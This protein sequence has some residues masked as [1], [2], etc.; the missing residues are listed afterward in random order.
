MG[1]NNMKKALCKKGAFAVLGCLVLESSPLLAQSCPGDS[2]YTS[3]NGKIFNNAQP[4]STTLGIVHLQS[5]VFG[6]MKCGII[7]VPQPGSDNSLSEIKFYHTLSCD[8]DSAVAP[9]G[10]A[11]HSGMTLD[12]RGVKTDGP[13]CTWNGDEVS[14]ENPLLPGAIIPRAFSFTEKSTPIPGTGRG[15]F[16]G[17][18]GTSPAGGEIIVKGTF[19]CYGSIDMKF[20]GHVLTCPPPQY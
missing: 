20:T 4:N 18:P 7:G 1:I 2:I 3:V 13:W 5:D 8:D 14:P 9:D 6:K 19:S 10:T 15:V 17:L 11:L 16:G 12:T